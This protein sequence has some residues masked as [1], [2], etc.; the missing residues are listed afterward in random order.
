MIKD[1]KVKLVLILALLV[2]S[3]YALWP[4]Y[5]FYALSLEEK[6]QMMET[7]DGI[8]E[9]QSLQS[10]SINLGLDL[11]GG[12]HLVMEA[13]VVTLFES[14]ARTKDAQFSRL[15]EAAA[16]EYAQD[17]ESNFANVLAKQFQAANVPMVTYFGEKL[18]D[19]EGVVTFLNEQAVDAV[20]RASQIIRNRVDQFGVS[21][22]T[23]QKQGDSRIIVE[24]PGIEDPAQAKNLIQ[25][26]ALLE[27]KLLREPQD[28]DNILR[29]LDSYFAKQDSSGLGNLVGLAGTATDTTKKDTAVA[30]LQ[31]ELAKS[32]DTSK[33]DTGS[34]L[35]S[36]QRPF[37]QYLQFRQ[38]GQA[39]LDIYVEEKNVDL[40]KALL[41][42]REGDRIKLKSEIQTVIGDGN[43]LLF[44]SRSEDE[45]FYVLYVVKKQAELSGAVVTQAKQDIYEGMD[46]SL[47]GKP[48]VTL[49]MT[50]DGSKQWARVTGANVN[51]R[52]A[53][54]LDNKVQ[55]APNIVERISGGN[56]Q[57]TG[58]ADMNEAKSLA[59]ALRAGSL[60]APV[61]ILEERTIGPSLGQD[62]IEA[63][64]F[65]SWIA[66]LIVALAMIAY[67]RTSGAVADLALAT[68]VIFLLGILT[69]FGFTLTLPGIAGIVLT[70]GMAVDANVLIYE[71]IREEIRLGKTVRASIEAGFSKA[72]V[73]IMDANITTFGTGL[74]LYQFGTGPIKG[75]AL[76]LMIGIVTTIFCGVFVSRVLLDLLYDRATVERQISI[77]MAPVKLQAQQ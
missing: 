72:F 46:P 50:D 1:K 31:A 49:K 12:I 41:Y 25:Q 21:E 52:I 32:T 43:E 53:V 47:A 75:F 61:R 76:T 62:S 9:L 40:I 20:D 22:P 64:Q 38:F 51:R 67:Y 18:K 74:V 42:R 48:I 54:V 68:N 57:I 58:M 2:L 13:D 37:T 65:A 45:G 33:T 44:S 8:R 4:T 11:K 17:P 14:L 66:I 27:F 73:T 28:V 30:G 26:T 23:I 36:N 70:M 15:L 6:Q 71:R 3:G 77:G 35:E 34:V 7:P 69:G 10:R 59:I 63:G 19:D 5:K 60:P 24:L 55:S 16:S 39:G 56:T 29:R